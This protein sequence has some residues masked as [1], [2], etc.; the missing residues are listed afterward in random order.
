MLGDILEHWAAQKL[1]ICVLAGTQELMSFFVLVV[2]FGG[3]V[4][5]GVSLSAISFQK[6]GQAIIRSVYLHQTSQYYTPVI[7]MLI[8]NKLVKVSL[9]PTTGLILLTKY[10]IYALFFSKM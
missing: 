5:W 8:P 7:T 2:V 9:Y 10:G 3:D 6:V 1:P 4:W